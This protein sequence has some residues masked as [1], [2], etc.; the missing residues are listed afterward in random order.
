MEINR[1]AQ[2]QIVHGDSGAGDGDDNGVLWKK[3]VHKCDWWAKEKA[4]AIA[5]SWILPW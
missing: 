1:T 2:A 4:R 5:K 3:V